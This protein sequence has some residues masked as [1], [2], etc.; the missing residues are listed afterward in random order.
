MRSRTPTWAADCSDRVSNWWTPVS[1]GALAAS[2]PTNGRNIAVLTYDLEAQASVTASSVLQNTATV[3]HFAGL[4]GG[5]DHTT[6]DLTDAATRPSR[7]R[8]PPRPHP[9]RKP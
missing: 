8:P 3:F 1:T 7:A 6:T 5:A 2:H 9:T 4:E